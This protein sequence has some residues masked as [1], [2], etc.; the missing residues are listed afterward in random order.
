MASPVGLSQVPWK[1]PGKNPFVQFSVC[2]FGR[3]RPFGSDMTTNP[4]RFSFSLP[5]P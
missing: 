3:P 2:P 1:A 5:R 4:G